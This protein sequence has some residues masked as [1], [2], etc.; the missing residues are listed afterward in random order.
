M[1]TNKQPLIFVT[2]DDSISAPGIHRLVECLPQEALIYVVAPREPHSGQSS[3]ITVKDPLRITE[4]PEY[5]ASNIKVFSVNG[6]PVD[7]VKIA[8]HTIL[9][10]VPD[11]GVA[12]INHG[13]NAGNSIIYSG[14]MGAVLEMCELGYNAAGFSLLD[15]SLKA[16]F[17]ASMPYV[18]QI[19][20]AL[21]ETRLPERVCLNVN[22]PRTGEIKGAKVVAAAK[23][24]WTDEYEEYTDPHGRKFYMLT[25]DLINEEPENEGTDLYWLS[26]GYASIVPVTPD[27]TRV[28]VIP[29]VKGQLNC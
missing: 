28:D 24:H 13:S 21:L 7:C 10:G 29:R 18:K 20:D 8:A 4:H 2:N 22:F 6:T 26:R 15:H 19:V 1:N 12:G 16:D 17:S 27:Q 11:L 5:S 14:T 3:A 25:G 9:P 23:S